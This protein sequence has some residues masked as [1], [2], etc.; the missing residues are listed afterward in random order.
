MKFKK[1]LFILLFLPSFLFAQHTIKATFSPAKDFKWAILYKNTPTGTRYIA[2]GKIE[3]GNLTFSLDSLAEKGV[4]KLV[5]AAPQAEYN[6]DIIY[7]TEEDIELTFNT[8]DGAIFQKS[9]ENILLNNYLNDFIEIGKKIETAY[10]QSTI[11]KNS[12]IKLYHQQAETQKNYE[13]TS[14]GKLVNHFIKANHPYIPKEYESPKNYI[15]NLSKNY[16]KHI[17][18]SDTVL[19]SSGFLIEKSLAYI[20]GIIPEGADKLSAYNNNIDTVSELTTKTSASFQ[21][22]FLETLW[23]KL[24][25]YKLDTT[26]NYLAE[27]H[28][29]PIATQFNDTALALKLT[30]FKN[31]S[32]GNVAPNFSWETFENGNTKTH[33]LTDL[34][35]AEN[36]ILVFWSSSCSHCLKE[37]PKLKTF[38]KTLDST[39]YKVVAI[40]LEDGSEKWKKEVE[41]YPEFI[42]VIKLKK[43]DSS[44]VTEYGLT[45]TPTYFLLDKDKKFLAKPNSLEELIEFIGNQK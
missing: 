39:T 42:N 22:S 31:L 45:S 29:I 2:Q 7:N 36:Y 11:D 34:A 4:Y 17:N 37:I 32:I 26:A 25:Y 14:K 1:T 23:Q 41:K 12:I 8:N 15:E 13:E 28:L 16:F 3:N 38:V 30:Q 21:K 40:G 44:V 35:V 43:W 33:Q 20:L 19:Q 10:S 6:F 24:V 9:S 18:F 27:R 5:Y